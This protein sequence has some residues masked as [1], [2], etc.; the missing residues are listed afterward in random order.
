MTGVYFDPAVGGDGSTV[1]DDANAATGL[2]NGGHRA[3]FVG[4]LA[5]IVAIAQVV[6]AKAAAAIAAAA[7]AVNAPGTSATSTTTLTIATGAIGLTIQTGKSLVVGMS[8]KVANTASPTNW[9]AGDITAYNAATGA[10]NVNVVLTAGS[11]SASGWTVSLAGATLS[12]EVTAANAVTLTN[13]TI[14]YANN[15]LNG[16]QETLV[17]GTNIKTINS[18]SLIG[19]G[20][21]TVQATLVSG[22][23]IKTIN[24]ATILGSGNIIALGSDIGYNNVGSLCFCKRYATGTN[25]NPGDSLA[26]SAIYP[27]SMTSVGGI[28]ASGSTLSGTWRLLGYMGGTDAAGLF[29]RIA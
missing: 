4:A 8:V 9:M 11:G 19:A 24:G 20:N 2:A 6:V 5:Q 7:T 15:T 22:T 14:N 23:N 29:Q 18:S 12:A 3:R 13:K 21:I 25:L 16:V 1:T 10:L 27:A 17:S 28:N 26:G